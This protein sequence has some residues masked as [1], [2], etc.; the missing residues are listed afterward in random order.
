MNQNIKNKRGF[1]STSSLNTTISIVLVQKDAQKVSEYLAKAQNS[2]TKRV[3]DIKDFNFANFKYSDLVI[4]YRDH[5]YSIFCKNTLCRNIVVDISK[6]M[7][8]NCICFVYE[9]CSGCSGYYLYKNGHLLE[10]YSYGL[11]YTEEIAGDD[12]DYIKEIEE[13]KNARFDTWLSDGHHEY[14]FFSKI[15]KVTKEEI[16]DFS[17]FIDNFFKSQDAWLPDLKYILPGYISGKKKIKFNFDCLNEE[18][19]P[20]VYAV[21]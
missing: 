4:Q 15:R 1:K 16:K 11:D 14:L 3:I 12:Q 17:T 18:E 21:I 7:K 5:P 19:L 20:I 9:D 2:Q 10:S 13:N 8:T 6:I